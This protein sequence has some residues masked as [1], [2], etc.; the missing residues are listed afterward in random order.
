MAARVVYLDNAATTMMPPSALAALAAWTNRGNPS[1]GYASAREAR[2]LIEQFRAELAAYCAVKLPACSVSNANSSGSASTSSTASGSGSDTKARTATPAEYELLITSGGSESNCTIVRAVTEAYTRETRRMPHVISTEIEHHSLL[3]CLK[4]LAAAR[5][6]QLTLI[7]PNGPGPGCG[8]IDPEAVGAAVQPNTALVSVMAANNET[9]VLNNLPA[10]SRAVSAASAALH[11]AWV[12]QNSARRYAAPA[13]AD[14][15]FSAPRAI[16]IHSDAVQLFG[17]TAFSPRELGIDAFSV[18]FHKLGGPPGV[19]LLGIRRQLVD[20]QRLCPL[21]CGTQNGGLRGGTEAVHQIAAAYAGFQETA[22]DR[23]VKNRHLMALKDAVR[24]ELV[25]L[26]LECRYLADSDCRSNGD[27][28]SSAGNSGSS[29]GSGDDGPIVSKPGVAQVLWVAPTDDR[30]V[31]PGTLLLSVVPAR[32]TFFC[33]LK[34][35]AAL[36]RQGYI[37]SV[38]SACNT[39]NVAPSHVLKALRLAPE[40]ARGTLRVTFSSS[41]RLDDARAFARA[42]AILAKNGTP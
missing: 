33:N 25:G 39:Q 22:A 41:T 24:G 3:A 36:E 28:G 8:M 11:A 9:G 23:A 19:G 6:I 15:A 5:A 38:G 31:L 37:V 42:L 1:A 4:D 30:R 14:A 16:P 40:V 21:V 7:P 13:A 12:R 27:S 34:A 10:I 26:G 29:T 17:K 20:G 32:G 2:S 18:S 35:R